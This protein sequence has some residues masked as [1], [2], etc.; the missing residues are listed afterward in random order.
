MRLTQE[1]LGHFSL[2]SFPG[3]EQLLRGLHEL[4]LSLSQ[5]HSGLAQ[6]IYIYERF[7]GTDELIDY[8][9]N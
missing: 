9:G 6:E 3:I 4:G 8:K 5:I 7:H 2:R 1:G